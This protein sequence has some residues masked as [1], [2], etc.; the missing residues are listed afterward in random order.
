MLFILLLFY[1]FNSRQIEV[2]YDDNRI[3]YMQNHLHKLKGYK[4]FVEENA[5]MLMLM[6]D[7]YP[8][9]IQYLMN[10]ITFLYKDYEETNAT[11]GLILTKLYKDL[12]NYKQFC[13]ALKESFDIYISKMTSLLNQKN[14][15]RV[16]VN[17]LKQRYLIFNIFEKCMKEDEL[18]LKR[19]FGSIQSSGIKCLK[20]SE[21]KALF[22]GLRQKTIHE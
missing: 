21:K 9:N 12:L 8:L 3:H 2:D 4:V 19:N 13:K 1:C 20:A 22:H 18:I 15:N 17:K 14:I 6:K 16:I 7:C 5:N 10:N 11:Q